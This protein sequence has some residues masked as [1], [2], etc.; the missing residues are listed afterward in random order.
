MP[1][2]CSQSSTANAHQPPISSYLTRGFGY[3]SSVEL[4]A[5]FSIEMLTFFSLLNRAGWPLRAIE[6]ITRASQK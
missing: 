3:F 4:E 1:N 5:V 2:S 6:Q